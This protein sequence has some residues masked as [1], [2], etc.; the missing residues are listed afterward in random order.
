MPPEPPAPADVRDLLVSYAESGR[1]EVLD[2]AVDVADRLLTVAALDGLDATAQA[3]VWTLGAAALTWSA[4]T[5]AA[6]AD[7]LDRA[8][9]WMAS[10]VQAWPPS[11]QNLPITQVN[12]ATAL[13]DRFDLGGDTDDLERAV[14]LFK[15]ALP[16]LAAT[17]RR[18]DTARHS[19]G[20]C[21]HMRA[22]S[23]ADRLPDLDRAIALF[24]EALADPAA[25]AEERA[26][27]GNSLG[28]SLRRK[29][30]DLQR[31]RAAAR[32]RGDLPQGARGRRPR[33]SDGAG[34]RGEPGDRPARPCRPRRGPGAAARSL[35]IYRDLLPEADPS[36]QEQLTTNLAGVLVGIYR[37]EHDRRLL[38]EAL[39]GVRASV[40]RLLDGPRRRV[41]LATLAGALHELFDHTGELGFLDEA[42]SL[43]RTLLGAADER[44]DSR[45]L[46]LGIS[47]LARF[48]HRRDRADLD[49]ACGLFEQAAEG[50]AAV[51]VASAHNSHVNALSLAFDVSGNGAHIDRAILQRETA[52]RTAVPGSLDDAICRANLGV[53]LLKRFELSGDP[54]DL[55]QAVAE[56]RKA[57]T[58][59]P[60]G[61]ADQ[62]RLL[63][64]LADSLARRALRD[65]D[66]HMVEEVRS[67]YRAAVRA[68]RESLPEQALGAAARW[69]DWEVARRSWDEA[70]AAYLIGLY[71]ASGLVARQRRRAD[72]ESWLTDAGPLPT[73]AGYALAR[74][75]NPRS[76]AVAIEQGRAVLLAE[77]LSGR[78]RGAVRD[79]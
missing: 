60:A 32:G 54:R 8:I 75:G 56:Q 74:S 76:A 15:A 57:V 69:G 70:A 41:A 19:F 33:R 55:N 52:I 43:Q 47:L 73:A 68:G 17:G 77:A 44:I 7:D 64:A 29:S 34:D 49:E 36:M 61:S 6:R 5:S 24:R 71:T 10:A 42:I 25:D 40:A 67:T 37:F 35:T 48:R 66:P 22:G 11:D 13:S 79:P 12:L 39:G 3:M 63:A 4:R 9:G 18:V 45:R 26:G 21:L 65:V 51:E 72:K 20:V 28:L 16:A 78:L 1:P 58:I 30:P 59:V 62:P 31:T 38:D 14:P 53:D 27:Y 2:K 46:N 50:G 23:R